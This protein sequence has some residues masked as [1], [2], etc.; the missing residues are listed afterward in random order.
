MSSFFDNYIEVDE[1][2]PLLETGVM[3]GGKIREIL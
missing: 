3:E 2:Q 1:N